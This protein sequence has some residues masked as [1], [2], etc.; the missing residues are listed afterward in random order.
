M[1]TSRQAGPKH[2]TLP[3]QW[4]YGLL[5]DLPGV[6]GLLA[7]V[8]N[9]LLHSL[10]PS[11]GGTGLRG[12][13]VHAVPHV[14]RQSASIATRLTSGDE[15]PNVPRGEAGLTSIYHDFYISEELYFCKVDLTR[16]CKT[17]GVLP[18]VS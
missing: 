9:G 2:P 13:A 14:L 12:L 3:A 6:P 1:P 4:L 18:V 15:W 11:V 17:A 8:T 10:D 7:S 5:R 16:F